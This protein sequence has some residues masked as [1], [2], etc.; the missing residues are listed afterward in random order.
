MQNF[1]SPLRWLVIPLVILLGAVLAIGA[2][3][4]IV[5]ILAYPQLPPIDV[6]TDYRPKIP[7]RVFT[8]DGYLIGEFGEERRSMVA[9]N[10]V[11]KYSALLM[12]RYALRVCTW[13][14]ALLVLIL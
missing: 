6:L 3:L 9:I 4:A 8:S 5:A 11:L 1:G 10:Q 2:M 7:L 12:N 13:W 14:N